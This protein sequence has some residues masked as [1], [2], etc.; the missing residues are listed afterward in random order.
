[1]TIASSA[2]LS[3]FERPRM[4][5]W[6]VIAMVAAAVI[7][8]LPIVVHRTVT[9]GFGD[10]Q[11]FFRAAWAIW[12][13][14]PL[15][16]VTDNHGWS[17]LYTPSFALVMAPFADPLPGHPQPPWAL[18]FPAAVG[19]WYAI[20]AVAMFAAVHVWAS[21]IERLS[22]VR[23]RPAYWQSWWALRLGP[24]LALLTFAGGGL[25]AGQ[26]TAILILLMIGFLVLYAEGRPHG[27]AFLLAAAA[28]IKMFPIALALIP[29]LRRDVRTLLSLTVWCAILLIGLPLVCLGPQATV[30]LYRALWV[31][32]LAGILTGVLNPRIAMELSPWASD[33]GSIGSMLARVVDGGQPPQPIPLPAWARYTQLAANVAMVVLLAALGHGRF[34]SVRKEQPEQPYAILVAGAVFMAAMPAMISVSEPHYWAQ[35]MP[36]VAIMVAETWRR[37]AQAIVSPAL[38]VWTLAAWFSML[39][40][41]LPIW[42]PLRLLGPDTPVFLTLVGAGFIVLATLNAARSGPA[43]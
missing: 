14:Y 9:H 8:Y 22:G 5:E 21:T 23:V 34:W 7:V 26:P 33:V 27:A 15:Y 29:V 2:A 41:S 31:E 16:D 17:Y 3:S 28:A 13:G 11:V 10:A 35:A 36:L 30:D 6:I 37:A 40:T 43:R 32:R 12:T 1:M 24:L 18:P 19:T 42:Q 39:A 4:R 20:G 25:G 38:F